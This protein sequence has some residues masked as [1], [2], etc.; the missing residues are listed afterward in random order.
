MNERMNERMNEQT[1][2]KNNIYMKND[3]RIE[4]RSQEL[5]RRTN[6]R[7]PNC[8]SSSRYKYHHRNHQ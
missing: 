3:N 8:L 1:W 6:A 7:I 4:K 5:K 2:V